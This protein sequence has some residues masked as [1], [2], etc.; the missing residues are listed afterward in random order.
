M[1]PA[2][3]SIITTLVNFLTTKINDATVLILDEWPEP[4]YQN[5]DVTI[6]ITTVGTPETVNRMPTIFSQVDNVDPDKLD[7]TYNIGQYNLGIQIDV[8]TDYKAKRNDWY[9]KISDILDSQF[10]DSGAPVG[11]SLTMDDY[12]GAI[13]RYD[14][15]GYNYSDSEESVQRSEWRVRFD[16]R[17]SFP[18]LILKT[19]SKI[20]EATLVTDINEQ[21]N[22]VDNEETTVIF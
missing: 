15:V 9:Q 19:E 4:G 2:N 8:W 6:A 11:L 1:I 5:K 13:A 21:E 16:L 3:E 20:L 22:N 12:L 7:V 17:A 10:I 14:Q 18:K